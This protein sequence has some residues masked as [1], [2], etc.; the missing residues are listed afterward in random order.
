MKHKE[1][2]LGFPVGLI[3]FVDNQPV[4]AL[5]WVKESDIPYP[6]PRK[7]DDALFITCVYNKPGAKYDYRHALV[8]DMK[9]MALDNGYKW[10]SVIAGFETPYPNGPK[11][12]FESCGF[13]EGENLGR[14]LL[15][16]RWDDIAFMECELSTNK[17]KGLTER[18]SYRLLND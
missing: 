15:R 16:Y 9:A 6:I 17:L 18:G 3:A 7:R 4:A 12:L 8:N 5:E 1:K 14:L 13:V 10:I 2:R 11:S